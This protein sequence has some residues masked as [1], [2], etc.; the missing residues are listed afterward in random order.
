MKNL[1]KY[2]LLLFFPALAACS[3]DEEWA[4]VAQQPHGALELSIGIG[5]FTTYGDAPATRASESGTTTTFENGDRA[6]IIVLEGGTL[7]GNNLPYIYNNGSWSFDA[8]QVNSENSNKSIYY[9]DS[10]ATNV[11]YIVY[12]P[13]STD[14]DGVTV[15]DG[16]GGLKSKFTPKENQQS[17]ADYRASDLMTWQSADGIAPQKKLSVTLSH[18]CNSVSL[19]P[20]VHYTLANGDDFV[21]PSPDISDV[22]FVIDGKPRLPY[23]AADGSYR[24]ILPSGLTESSVRCFYTFDRKTFSKELTVSSASATAAN[25]RYSSTQKVS[26][27]DYSLD[28]AQAGD[29][30]CKSSDGTTGYLIPGDVASLNEAHRAACIG[31]VYCTDVNRIG[32]AATEALKKKGVNS[33]HGLVMALTNASDACRWGDKNRDENSDGS[34]GTPFKDNIGTLQKQYGNVDGYGETQWIINTYGSSGT[35][36]K[37]TYTAFYHAGRYG[38]AEGGTAQY[39]APDNTTGWFIPSMGQWWDILS[40]LGGIDLSDYRSSTDSEKYISDA[41]PIAVENM[42]KYL[43]KISGATTFSTDTHFW[44]SSEYDGGG[45]CTV[46]FA[47]FGDLGLGGRPKNKGNDRVRCS[48]AF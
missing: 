23:A 31:I 9:Y 47:S 21:H 43:Q 26:A 18:A 35:T 44:P 39:A 14:A 11:T 1:L 48:F 20:V 13:Y 5:D 41:A 4:T 25:I 19:L 37:D 36:L 38:T 46:F 30:Y 33:P 28:M 7:K 16:E 6:G 24:Y 15:L 42:N 3:N 2:T 45:A 32:T 8:N 40:G 29:F 22:N 10:K 17:V 12:Y 34:A 27:G